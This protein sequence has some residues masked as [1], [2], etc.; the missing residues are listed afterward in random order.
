MPDTLMS[1]LGLDRPETGDDA[2][3]PF[4]LDKLDTRG[5]SVR[6]G[7]ALDTI[8]SRH[9]YPAPVARLLGE[10]VVLAGLIGSSLKFEGRFIMQTQTDGPVNLIVVDF[11]APDGLRGYARFDHDALV[12][13]AET[14]KTAPGELLGKGHLAMTI[15]QGP[16]TERY[17]GIVAL[18]GESLEEVAHTYFMQSEQIP[19]MVRLAVAEFRQ[20]GDQRPHWRAGGILIQHLPEHG[21]GVKA[22]LPGDGSAANDDPDFVEPDG[23]TEAKTLLATL[24][25]VELADPDLSPERL[26]F[27]LYHET[28]VRVFTPAP[29]VER[30]TCSADRIEAMLAVSFTD[31]DREDMAVDGEIEVVCEFCSTAYHFNPHQFDVKH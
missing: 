23:W 19:T 20:K 7:D 5:R 17:Q 8:L 27:R 29:L 4:T 21:L 16:D 13:A 30:C 14:G 18:E 24:A 6:L 25:D 2:V 28:G 26:L 3:V 22:D 10:A 15:D 9:N 12:K 31:E 11:D 1:S